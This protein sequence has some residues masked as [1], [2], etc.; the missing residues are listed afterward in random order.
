MHIST[1]VRL[2]VLVLPLTIGCG[3]SAD[4]DDGESCYNLGYEDGY[5]AES[6]DADYWDC[7]GSDY[8]AYCDGYC[9]GEYDAFGEYIECDYC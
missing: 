7:Y 6:P 8:D 2:A 9:D 1:L 5:D 4:Y 3:A